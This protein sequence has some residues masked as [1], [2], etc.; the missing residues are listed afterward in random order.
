MPLDQLLIDVLACPVDKGPLLWF[1]DEN[2]LYNPRL[3]KGYEVRDDIPV[4]LVDEARDVDD[5]E[6][7]RLMAKA[8]QGGVPETGSAGR[9]PAPLA[10]ERSGAAEADE[11]EESEEGE[12][13]A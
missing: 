10:S 1:E 13:P 8:K 2:L 6:H 7:E 5:S 12:S 4:L 9:K 3:K 11:A